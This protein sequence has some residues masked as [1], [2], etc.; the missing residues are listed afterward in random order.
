MKPETFHANRQELLAAD[1]D[2]LVDL[3]DGLPPVSSRSSRTLTGITP[4]LALAL[5]KPVIDTAPWD[6]PEYTSLQVSENPTS[7]IH[8]PNPRSNG[9]GYVNALKT[10]LSNLP[11]GPIALYADDSVSEVSARQTLIPLALAILCSVPYVDKHVVASQLHRLVALWPD[12]NPPR[13][14][15]KRVNQVLMPVNNLPNDAF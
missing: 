8:L 3:V 1:R 7:S 10:A 14:A 5:G 15:L 11:P 13:A 4:R 12:G 9:K 2:D 6:P